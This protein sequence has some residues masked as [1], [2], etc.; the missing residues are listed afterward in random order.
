MREGLAVSMLPRSYTI[1][2]DGMNAFA[3]SV[4]SPNSPDDSL[5]RV[6]VLVRGGSEARALPLPLI[7]CEEWDLGVR[8]I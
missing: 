8:V 7:S 1:L 6:A 5:V 3:D 2:V 4:Y